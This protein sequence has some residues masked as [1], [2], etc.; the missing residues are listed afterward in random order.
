MVPSMPLTK[1]TKTATTNSTYHQPNSRCEIYIKEKKKMFT[2]H[3]DELQQRRLDEAPCQVFQP[4]SASKDH[5]P[6]HCSS[7]QQGL[8]NELD[9]KPTQ[10]ECHAT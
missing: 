8:Q 3:Q 4:A 1:W 7:S 9:E 2:Y 6:E 5:K 10:L